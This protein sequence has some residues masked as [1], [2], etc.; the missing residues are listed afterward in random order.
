MSNYLDYI[1]FFL[2]ILS[3][4]LFIV[5]LIWFFE[6]ETN[7]NLPISIGFSVVVSFLWTMVAIV[8]GILDDD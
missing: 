5:F 4:C 1:K 6:L 7:I 2:L 3:F 8:D